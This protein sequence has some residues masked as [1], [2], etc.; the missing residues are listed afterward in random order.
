MARRLEMVREGRRLLHGKSITCLIFAS[1]PLMIKFSKEQS[2]AGFPHT[3]V[4]LKVYD[5][6]AS[7]VRASG[8]PIGGAC[9][10]PAPDR[11]RRSCSL[12]TSLQ[13]DSSSIQKHPRISYVRKKVLHSLQPSIHDVVPSSIRSNSHPATRRSRTGPRLRKSCKD[14]R[15][16]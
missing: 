12:I 6:R 3:D 1:R 15:R 8:L 2:E 5:P 9:I 13:Q 7:H 4:E 10:A 16:T 11:R 14:Q